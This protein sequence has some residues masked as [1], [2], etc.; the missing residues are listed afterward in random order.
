MYLIEPQETVSIVE[1][2]TGFDD[3][4]R[5]EIVTGLEAGQR[6]VD[7]HLKRFSSGQKVTLMAN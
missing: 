2:S 1:V 5:I 6:V 3:G 4:R 7:A